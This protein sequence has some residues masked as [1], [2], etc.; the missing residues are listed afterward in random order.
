M[1][2]RICVLTALA[3]IVQM[4]S[5]DVRAQNTDRPA[6]V[7]LRNQCR[8]AAQIVRSGHPV[9]K[10]AWA[11]DM[12]GNC[13]EE[14]PPVLVEKWGD[15]SLDSI[16][17]A[18]VLDASSG[19]RDGRLAEVAIRIA[20]DSRFPETRRVA[21]MLLLVRYAD[22]YTGLAV[23]LLAPPPDWNAGQDVR[24][25]VG[26]GSSHPI[27]QLTGHVPLP[28]DFTSNIIAELKSVAAASTDARVQYVATGLAKRLEFQA[29]QRSDP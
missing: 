15:I 25:I 13:A 12:I 27:P 24:M 16:R 26:W 4:A 2:R 20:H 8:L 22:P 11:L 18:R 19:I 10:S 7:N 28:E 14:G 21:A 6:E 3:L 29:P 9:N 17:S 5:S 1:P 23:S